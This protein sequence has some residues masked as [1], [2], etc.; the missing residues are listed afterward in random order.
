RSTSRAAN[1]P[2][3]TSPRAS[4]PSTT[5]A[6]TAWACRPPTVSDGRLRNHEKAGHLPG[7]FVSAASL[8]G[9]GLVDGLDQVLVV[10]PGQAGEAGDHL[11][12]AA[13]HVL[14]EVPARRAALLGQLAEQRH[15]I[16][17][18]HRL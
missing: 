18:T 9:D 11:A 14:V 7:F 13:H 15:G 1:W 5:T 3:A 16:V 8:P 12:V 6:L 17:A 10:R 4:A 2:A